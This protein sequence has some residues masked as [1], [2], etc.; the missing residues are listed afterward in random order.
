MWAGHRLAKTLEHQRDMESDLACGIIRHS[1]ESFL[2][3]LSEMAEQVLLLLPI[4]EKLSAK[5]TA[6]IE[7]TQPPSF[8]LVV[9]EEN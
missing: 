8:T 4:A 5:V 6:S 1:D 9:Q 3:S 7:G 2:F